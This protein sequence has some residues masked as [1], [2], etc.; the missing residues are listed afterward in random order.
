MRDTPSFQRSFLRASTYL[1]HPGPSSAAERRKILATAEGRGLRIPD[2]IS[3]RAAK[4]YFAALRL[5]DRRLMV[6][7][8]FFTASR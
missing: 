1:T 4:E 6:S 7:T 2:D 5:V 8:A 3:R